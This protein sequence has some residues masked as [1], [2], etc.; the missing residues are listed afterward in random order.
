MTNFDRLK[1][2]Y[3]AAPERAC[4]CATGDFSIVLTALEQMYLAIG[5]D[6]ITVH[7][8]PVSLLP[9]ME[10][11]HALRDTL[12]KQMDFVPHI[13]THRFG[14]TVYVVTSTDGPVV[15]TNIHEYGQTPVAKAQLALFIL[16]TGSIVKIYPDE[17]VSNEDPIEISKA[18]LIS[19]L[20]YNNREYSV[21]AVSGTH[22]LMCKQNDVGVM[23][24]Y[25]VDLNNPQYGD[26]GEIV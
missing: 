20:E 2:N 11:R 15:G 5:N 22:I 7:T 19:L 14:D 12:R 8:C 25:L 21:L 24:R 17:D 13:H 10:S 16:P 9:S 1:E 3:N 23:V 4:D 6:G 26:N 18:G